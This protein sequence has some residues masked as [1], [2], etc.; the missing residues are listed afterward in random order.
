MLM[1]DLED[2]QGRG[3][4]FGM[5][6]DAKEDVSVAFDT[7]DAAALTGEEEPIPLR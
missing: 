3:M 4:S 7:A 2:A 1:S 6:Y 5:R